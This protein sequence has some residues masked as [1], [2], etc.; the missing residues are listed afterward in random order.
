MT[1]DRLAMPICSALLAVGLLLLALAGCGPSKPK[2]LG[3]PISGYN[4]TSASI[5]YFTVNGAAGPNIGPYQGGGGQ[6]CCGMLPHQ[7]YPGL[8]VVVE[9]EKDSDP[10]GYGKWPEPMFSKEWNKR[11]D[12]HRTRYTHHQA[13]VEVPEYRE[14]LCS[15]K[16]HFLPCDQV[17]VNTTC[18][19]PQ[20]PD[21]PYKELFAVKEPKECP[22][23]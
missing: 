4:H 20:H 9:W 10:Y 16:A 7:W 5:N 22:A 14:R 15:I 23:P 1:M 12:E 19:T 21:Y 13:V 6:S 3:T 11:M 17:Q 8:K 18:M 2:M